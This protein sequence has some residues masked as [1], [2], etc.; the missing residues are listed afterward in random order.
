[1]AFATDRFR[2]PNKRRAPSKSE[3]VAIRRVIDQFVLA[4]RAGDIEG[5]IALCA[6]GIATFDVLP[7][8]RHDGPNA[9]RKL[10]TE[11]LAPFEAPLDYEVNQLEIIAGSDVAICRS[12]NRFGGIRRDGRAVVSWL[13]STIGL[14]KMDGRWKIVHEHTSVPFDMDSGKA[15]LHL[16]A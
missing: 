9:L 5:L 7:P 13:C 12:L 15:L 3:E 11:A 6:P 1:M 8:L 2:E 16:G 4:V 14:R 10:W